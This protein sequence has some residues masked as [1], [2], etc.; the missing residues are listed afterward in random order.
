MK[1]ESFHINGLKFDAIRVMQE[2]ISTNE[3]WKISG[4]EFAIQLLD[5]SEAP[6]KFH[7]S[8]TTGKPKEISFSKKQIL[9]SAKNTCDFFEIR[10]DSKLLLCLPT[11]FV[12]GRM[13][14]ARAFVSGAKLIW[15]EPSLNPLT[16]IDEVNF[17]AFTPA[18]VATIIADNETR[19]IFEKIN[20]VIIGGGEI[21]HALEKDLENLK[22]K[23]FATYGMTETL[24]HVAV[25]KIGESVYRSVYKEAVFLVD[26]NNCLEIELPVIAST[27]II[28]KD[29]VE[30][31]DSQS[32]VWKGRLDHVINTGGIKLYAEE[33]EKKLIQLGLLEENS[34]YIG[35]QKDNIFG[36]VPVI[37]MLKEKEPSDMATF[38]PTINGLLKKHEAVKHV[39]FFDKFEYTETGKLIR[40]KF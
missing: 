21:S 2:L 7:T 36:Q 17:A 18:Q 25:R 22:N 13:M 28:T 5:A 23:I 27:K 12:A 20:T 19:N 9:Y 10:A 16:N 37:V 14:M 8:G 33:M 15:K 30:L 11:D 35:S 6:V 38:L 31:V 34:F 1:E 32:F 26:E 3:K 40:Q 39:V 24:T 4:L 29:I